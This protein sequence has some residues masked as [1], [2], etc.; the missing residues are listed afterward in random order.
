MT[1]LQS[2]ATTKIVN[3]FSSAV[4][5]AVFMSRGVVDYKLGSILGVTMFVGA[6]VGGHTAMKLSHVWLR[7]IFVT[8]VLV[9]AIKM[10]VS[11]VHH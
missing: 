10:L 11:F 9:L 2:V 6:M 4:A 5:T 8:A 7:R 3:V 1:L